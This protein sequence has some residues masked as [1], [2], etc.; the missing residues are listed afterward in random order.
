MK[1]Y[2]ICKN[3]KLIK[4]LKNRNDKTSKKASKLHIL[5]LNKPSILHATIIIFYCRLHKAQS[6]FFDPRQKRTYNLSILFIFSHIKKNFHIRYFFKIH[7]R[8]KSTVDLMSTYF[9]FLYFFDTFVRNA[10]KHVYSL[11]FFQK[12]YHFCVFANIVVKNF[13][14]SLYFLSFTTSVWHSGLIILSIVDK[15]LRI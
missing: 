2:E 9:T 5:V 10:V 15:I 1:K 8:V 7:D 13:S 4:A 14:V 3:V 6:T 12:I 11:T